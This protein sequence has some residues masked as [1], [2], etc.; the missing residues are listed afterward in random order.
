MEIKKLEEII[1]LVDLD[2]PA[3]V[4]AV[5]SG[6]TLFELAEN[7]HEKSCGQVL[8]AIK[9]AGKLEQK[10]CEADPERKTKLNPHKAM[11]VVVRAADESGVLASY[12]EAMNNLFYSLEILCRSADNAGVWLLIENPKAGLMLSPLEMRDIIDNMSCPWVGVYF[13]KK[14]VAGVKVEDYQRILGKR[15]IAEYQP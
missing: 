12:E 15:I 14:N 13:N 5:D 3:L 9:I 10:Y 6:V 2:S 8:E 4:E 7:D 1:S 11:A